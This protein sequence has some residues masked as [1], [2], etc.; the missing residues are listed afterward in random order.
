LYAAEAL[1]DALLVPLSGDKAVGFSDRGGGD[2]VYN[3]YCRRLAGIWL[4]GH[5]S[6]FADIGDMRVD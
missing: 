4:E 5:G 3:G 1:S 2:Y 6:V